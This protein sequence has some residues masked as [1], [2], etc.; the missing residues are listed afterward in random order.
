MGH[1]K[2]ELKMKNLDQTKFCLGLKLEH[3]PTSILV[4]QSAYV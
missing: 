1:L 3:L 4:H 2:T